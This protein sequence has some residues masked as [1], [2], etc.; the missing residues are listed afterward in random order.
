MSMLRTAAFCTALV[1][2]GI[3]LYG[4]TMDPPPLFTSIFTWI[5]DDGEQGTHKDRP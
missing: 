3:G 4:A 1:M 2:G 5:A